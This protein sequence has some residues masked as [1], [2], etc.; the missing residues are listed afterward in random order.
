MRNFYKRK[1]L[2]VLL[3]LIFSFCCFSCGN[4]NDDT[5]IEEEEQQIN[6]E[7]FHT[8][9]I[10]VGYGDSTLIRFPD[11]KS[12]LIDCGGTELAKENIINTLN[13]YSVTQLDYLILTNTLDNHIGNAEYFIQN[14]GVKNMFIPHVV[15]PEKIPT[16]NSALSL[17]KSLEVNVENSEMFK[18]ITS[19]DSILLFLAPKPLLLDDGGAYLEF[20]MA[21]NPTTTQIKNISPCFYLEYK[22]VRILLGGDAD[23]SQEEYVIEYANKIYN[24][25][26]DDFEINLKEIDVYK[27]QNHGDENS[28]SEPFLN[29]LK[30]KYAVV[31]VGGNNTQAHPSTSAIARLIAAS[32]NCNLLRTDTVGN[33]FLEINGNG[34]YTINNE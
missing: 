20:N 33:I 3:A 1:V 12:V 23:K 25:Y 22:D 9:F 27:M 21:K 6:L 34:E 2:W 10:D 24:N 18:K 13:L 15:K 14:Y 11:G 30:P 4:C 31:S 19:E 26:V 16:F 8:V 32:P 5:P 29:M 28:N 17:A 7:N